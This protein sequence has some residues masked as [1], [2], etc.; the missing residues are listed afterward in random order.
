MFL[1]QIISCNTQVKKFLVWVVLCK[2]QV[3]KLGLRLVSCKTQ[4]KKFG[5]QLVSCNTQSRNLDLKLFHAIPSQEIWT[6]SCFMQY[7]SQQISLWRHIMQNPSQ[8][9]WAS[10]CFMQYP[11]QQI[12]NFKSFHATSTRTKKFFHQAH[13]LQYPSQQISCKIFLQVI[14]PCTL[15]QKEV[16][17]E[18]EKEAWRNIIALKLVPE[19]IQILPW[20]WCCKHN[21]LL[22]SLVHIPSRISGFVDFCVVCERW[23]RE[24]ELWMF[25]CCLRHRELREIFLD[26]WNVQM[27]VCVCVCERERERERERC[28]I[29]GLVLLPWTF[30]KKCKGENKTVCMSAIKP[31]FKNCWIQQPHY[32]QCLLKENF[33]T[34]A[35]PKQIFSSWKR[36]MYRIVAA[37]PQQGWWMMLILRNR[38]EHFAFC[39]IIIII[40]IITTITIVA[41]R[42][43]ATRVCC[44]WCML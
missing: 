28:W 39:Q 8:E 11:S 10:I 44:S 23:E 36:L 24:R 1:L 6:W 21:W 4:V 43:C 14:M 35:K 3:K 5:L 18:K 16:V 26:L 40:I 19:T 31:S 42:I 41:T 7:P 15:Q 20:S 13:F 33:T 29:C 30:F 9:I 37:V 34:D 25:N 27:C 12:S 38:L 17:E 32:K 22:R 2:T